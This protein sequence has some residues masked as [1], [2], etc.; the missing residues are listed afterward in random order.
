[1][2][3]VFY[4]YMTERVFYLG[5]E[6]LYLHNEFSIQNLEIGKSCRKSCKTYWGKR[7]NAIQ[8]KIQENTIRYKYFVV[9][10]VLSQSLA[11]W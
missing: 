9:G 5:I 8:K 10:I 4:L 2:I 7:C 11:N 6:V 1:M 3:S